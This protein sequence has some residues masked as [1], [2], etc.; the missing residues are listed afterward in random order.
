MSQL[1]DQK[2]SNLSTVKPLTL[3]LFYQAHS[4]LILNPHNIY[5]ELFVKEER[6]K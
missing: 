2:E 1:V 5:Q 4:T 3:L 6:D